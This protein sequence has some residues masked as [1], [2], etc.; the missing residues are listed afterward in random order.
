MPL[1]DRAAEG[2]P[3]GMRTRL[4]LAVS[5]GVTGLLAWSG[6]PVAGAAPGW[7]LPQA[8][9]ST[10]SGE[11]PQVALASD[12]RAVVVWTEDSAGHARV[13]AAERGTDGGWAAPVALSAAGD[14]PTSGQQV[15]M[16]DHGLAVATWTRNGRVL[17][18]VRSTAGVWTAPAQVSGKGHGSFPQVAVTQGG[19]AYV[20][21]EQVSGTHEQVRVVRR[22]S[23][24]T[25]SAPAVLPT[26]VGDAQYPVVAVDALG[27]ATVV[28]QRMWADGGRTAVLTAR[29]SGG[30]WS[31]TATLSAPKRNAG[32]PLLATNDRGDAVVT[33]SGRESGAV[34]VLG[35]VRP[36][37]RAWGPVRT[38]ATGS[39]GDLALD[40]SGV[41]VVAWT[42]VVGS[43]VRIGL[44]SRP[45]G[46]SW[47]VG[48]V[49]PWTAD[50]Q[51]TAPQVAAGGG[52][53]SLAWVTDRVEAVR[54][55]AGAW[56]SVA[57]VG[58]SGASYYQQVAMDAAGRAVVVWK[59]WDGVHDVVM[60]ST[61]GPS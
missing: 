42:A 57:D 61:S 7:S 19:R 9:S 17:V 29:F 58:S 28:W 22:D 21:W 59:Q 2:F 24:G 12:G 18:A 16:N 53:V 10:G 13:V 38:I 27:R 55:D 33:W 11:D 52:S 43:D 3:G 56:G 46:G 35:V 60:V 48:V 5:V 36:P 39:L 34:V 37:T 15:S 1:V 54:S 14:R 8:V 40:R 49:P 20:V 4:A 23:H 32:P 45:A 30:R 41:A 26:G 31:P 51:T 50:L 44:S 25:W 47:Q 6:A